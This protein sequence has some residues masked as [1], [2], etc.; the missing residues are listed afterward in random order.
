VPDRSPVIVMAHSPRSWARSL[1]QHVIDHGGGRIMASIMS[2]E[3]AL[4]PGYDVFVADDTTSFL[5]RKLV[6]ELRAL[7][8]AVVG[9]YDPEEA[10]GRGRERLIE[11]QV[12]E[13]VAADASPAEFLRVLAWTSARHASTDDDGFSVLVADMMTGDRARSNPR[14]G[15]ATSPRG[16]VVA[17]TGASG[18]VGATEIALGVASCVGGRAILIDADDVGPSVAQRLGLP[19]HPNLRSAVDVVTNQDGYL[20]DALIPVPAGGFAVVGGLANRRDWFEVR[21]ADVSEAVL[22]LAR[23]HDHV[24]VNVSSRLEDLPSI[25][26]PARYGVT[27]SLLTLADVII[28]VSA[29][30]PIGV[31]RVVDWFAEAKPLVEATPVHVVFNGLRA[32]LYKS[33]QIE[34]EL[35]HVYQTRSIHFVPHDRRLAHA[36][37]QGALVGRG[38]FLRAVAKLA[39]VLMASP[40]LLRGSRR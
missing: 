32:N 37:W 17:V 2:A 8:V 11:L 3:D 31:A 5:S 33:A 10:E 9:V 13:V 38:P 28:L 6:A 34:D 15:P 14:S 26:G 36:T 35:R 18:G 24:I 19:V 21:P 7:S 16:S 30:S 40:G 39:G 27:R 23:T 22:E 1:K 12:D 4:S 29:P 20:D 25:G